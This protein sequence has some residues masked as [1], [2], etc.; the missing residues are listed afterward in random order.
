MIIMFL[1]P[2]LL[3]YALKIDKKRGFELE[4]GYILK[5][6]ALKGE[7]NYIIATED[8]VNSPQSLSKVK[9]AIYDVKTKTR[10][11]A[12]FDWITPQGLVKGQSIYFRATK[13]R[14]EA[15][16]SLEKQE[17][18][19][20]RKIRDRGVLTGESNFFWA[21]EKKHYALYDIRTGKKLTPD[22]K[23][24]VIAGALIGDTDNLIVGSFGE[25]IFF[26]YDIKKEKVVSKEFDENKLIEI[27]KNGSI[28]Q[29]LKEL[30][31]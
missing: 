5:E 7:S 2:K 9:W 3:Y 26:I 22:F 29:A 12:F 15:I 4:F 20:F 19:W 24:S 23:S 6:G 21:K 28:K 31:I 18:P 13:N 8:K 30:K 27:I 14:K 25:E 11:T 17:T 10:F 1:F 16:F